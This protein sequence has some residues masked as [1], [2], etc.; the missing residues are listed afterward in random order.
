MLRFCIFL[1]GC[2]MVVPTLVVP[3]SGVEIIAHR[4]A[5][6]D[7]P[8]NTLASVNLAWAQKTDAVE[9]DIYL[10]ADGKIVAIHDDSTKRT[11]GLD[12]PVVR[13][14]LEE[15]KRLDAGSWKSPKYAG[16]KIPTL[17]EILRTIPEGK[18]LFIEIKAGP[19]I[20]PELK[21]VLR[22]EGK[23]PAQ[24]PCIGFSYETVRQT[25]KEIPELKVY[26]LAVLK[27]D[28]KTGQLN[29][30][31]AELIQK[32]KAAN[33]DGLDLGHVPPLNAE[34][35]KE[36]KQAGFPLFV[37]TVN[38]ADTAREYRDLGI[39][40][41]TTDRPEFLRSALSAPRP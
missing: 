22:Q 35:V 31:A 12:K 37:W 8:E 3:A 29:H 4:G 7:A 25:K 9:I 13:Q 17:E 27:H 38:D 26:W 5:S 23:P 1:A 20:V 33:L 6:H 40:G 36:I 18:R 28:E 41:I 24:T 19:E 30:T 10:T 32:T 14:T 21:R 2:L 15:L 16:E 39:D 11:A 34:F